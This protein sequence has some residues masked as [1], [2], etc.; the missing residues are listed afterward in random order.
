M[1]NLIVHERHLNHVSIIFL[2]K[3]LP[4]AAVLFGVHCL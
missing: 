2:L 4:S 3:K 1:R